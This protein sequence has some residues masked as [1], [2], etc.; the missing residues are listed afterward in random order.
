MP[1]ENK[2]TYYE[3]I[4]VTDNWGILIVEKGVLLS[5]DWRYASLT[6]PE[7]IEEKKV[8]GDGWVLELNNGYSVIKDENTGN[9]KLIKK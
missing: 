9:Y 7:K 4:R 6:I 3:S 1:V 2:G 5:P 8:S